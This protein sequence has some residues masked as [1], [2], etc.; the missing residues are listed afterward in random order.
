MQFIDEQILTRAM[1]YQKELLQEISQNILC[2]CSNDASLQEM[3]LH[4]VNKY[5]HQTANELVIRAIKFS[6]ES[7]NTLEGIERW[8]AKF[9]IKPEYSF[10]GEF[11]WLRLIEKNKD[12]IRQILSQHGF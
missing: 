12:K 9:G 4:A 7:D 5:D 3:F 10:M 8:C 1:K 11:D 6:T 2:I